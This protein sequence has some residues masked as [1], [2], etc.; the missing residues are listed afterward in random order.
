MT[1]IQLRSQKCCDNLSKSLHIKNKFGRPILLQ[2]VCVHFRP[3][4]KIIYLSCF[5]NLERFG[6]YCVHVFVVDSADFSAQVW[7]FKLLNQTSS[8]VK[9][10]WRLLTWDAP[11]NTFSLVEDVNIECKHSLCF[12]L[13]NC[14]PGFNQGQLFIRK[15]A[16]IPID[17]LSFLPVET[18]ESQ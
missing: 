10:M 4:A 7:P 1:K 5:C 14:L 6:A 15:K 9:L 3:F 11:W 2:C 13:W 18:D 16:Q 8:T 12:F 17:N